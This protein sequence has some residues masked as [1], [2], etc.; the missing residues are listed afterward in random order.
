MT[1]GGLEVWLPLA[2]VAIVAVPVA[3]VVAILCAWRP[4]WWR[5][6]VIPPI[7]GSVASLVGFSVALEVI[8]ARTSWPGESIGDFWSAAFWGIWVGAATGVV[9]LAVLVRRQR[10]CDVQTSVR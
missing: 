4:T 5:V 8:R 10:R 6:W 3:T 2:L 9:V 7:A 1:G